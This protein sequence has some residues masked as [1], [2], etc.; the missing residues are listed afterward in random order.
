MEKHSPIRPPKGTP[1]DPWEDLAREALESLREQALEPV[2]VEEFLEE[3]AAACV[4]LG[5]EIEAQTVTKVGL[6]AILSAYESRYGGQ[7]VEHQD[8][9]LIRTILNEKKNSL[10]ELEA[11]LRDRKEKVEGFLED[12]E[13]RRHSL[14]TSLGRLEA[15]LGEVREAHLAE[16]Q[17]M[18]TER[19]RIEKLRDRFWPP[20]GGSPVPEERRPLDRETLDRVVDGVL[21]RMAPDKEARTEL[22]SQVLSS[23]RDKELKSA[24]ARKAV[25]S[26]EDLPEVSDDEFWED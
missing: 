6:E 12:L 13:R 17:R 8:A 9:A 24:L 23:V 3:T 26:L 21:D 4:E 20:G 2:R 1:A 25:P 18:E 7:G 22:L 11:G 14:D 16:G 15:A 10:A 19:N 5:D